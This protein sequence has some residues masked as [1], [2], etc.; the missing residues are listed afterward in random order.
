MNRAN[1]SANFPGRWWHRLEDGRLQCDLCPRDCKLHDEQ[2]GARDE[3]GRAPA[4]K[5]GFGVERRHG[6]ENQRKAKQRQ[7]FPDPAGLEHW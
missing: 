1:G 7:P 5:R 2:R 3:Q 4:G 6:L